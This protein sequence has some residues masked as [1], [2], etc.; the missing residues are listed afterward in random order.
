MSHDQTRFGRVASSSG[1]VAGGWL[2]CRRRSRTSPW[3]A[4]CDT[5]WRSRPGRRPHPAAWRTPWPG[6]H[7]RARGRAARAGRRCVRPPTTPAAAASPPARAWVAGSCGASGRGSCGAAPPLGRPRRPPPARPAPG[8]PGRSSRL[9]ARR[10]GA[11]GG[12]LLQQRRELSLDLDHLAGLIQLAGQAL[13][14]PAQPGVLPLHRINRRPARGRT[15]RLER[16]SVTLLAPLGDQR[17]VQ[18]L[19]TQQRAL[20]GLVQPLVLGQDLGLVASRVT[21]GPLGPLG[22]L[23]VWSLSI[24]SACD[25]T[26]VIWEG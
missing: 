17:G 8:R 14:L 2:A 4:G 6:P 25:T 16:A 18:P 1:L 7:R 21:A 5:W 15:Q 26:V 20:A 22:N 23:R 10:R 9:A 12:E 13:V 19:A 3:Y 11:V 24:A